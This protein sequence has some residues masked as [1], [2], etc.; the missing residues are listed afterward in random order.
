MAYRKRKRYQTRQDMIKAF[1]KKFKVVIWFGLIA[2]AIVVWMNRISLFD[3]VR[4][5]FY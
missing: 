5:F 1:Y 2:L 3:Y 4:T